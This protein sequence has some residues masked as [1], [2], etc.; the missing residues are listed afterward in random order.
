M[1]VVVVVVGEATGCRK[2]RGKE[3]ERDGSDTTQYMEYTQTIKRRDQ[4]R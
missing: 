1:V 3:N 2:K 4:E